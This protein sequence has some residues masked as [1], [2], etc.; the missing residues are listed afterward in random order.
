M[1]RMTIR[2]RVR[3]DRGVGL[4]DAEGS[5]KRDSSRFESQFGVGDSWR[6]F[7]FA[8]A[9]RGRSRGVRGKFCHLLTEPSTTKCQLIVI[10]PSCVRRGDRKG[11]ILLF[12]SN[13]APRA[14][15]R[16]K[17]RMSPFLL[18][19]ASHQARVTIPRSRVGPSDE[20]A[21][22]DD[23]IDADQDQSDNKP[24]QGPP[25]AHTGPPRR[26]RS[27]DYCSD[28]AWPAAGWGTERRR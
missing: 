22:S 26:C 19:A 25:S 10:E 20:G 16:R 3:P 21:V 27:S 23:R 5:S 28:R 17:S 24:D 13:A 8:G 11:D 2:R 6:S 7:G 4:P 1:P 12:R 14:K 15:E 9:A 18:P